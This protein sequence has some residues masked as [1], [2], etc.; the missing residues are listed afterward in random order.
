MSVA[1]DVRVARMS[2]TRLECED[3]SAG[4]S[5]TEHYAAKVMIYISAD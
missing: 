3:V 2:A 1:H 5:M 4:S